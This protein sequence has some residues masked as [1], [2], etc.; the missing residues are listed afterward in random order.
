M[1][2][3]EARVHERLREPPAPPSPCQRRKHAK[4]FTER[5]RKRGFPMPAV[6]TTS[7]C[8]QDQAGS[9]RENVTADETC[10]A[11]LPHNGTI[12]GSFGTQVNS[13]PVA[14]LLTLAATK[15]PDMSESVPGV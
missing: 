13:P 8:A 10:A 15:L 5:C 1:Q 2:A 11:V 12:A 7:P 3:K 6:V 14:P 4:G 9:I